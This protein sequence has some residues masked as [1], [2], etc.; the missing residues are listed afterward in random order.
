[1]GEREM[2]WGGIEMGVCWDWF[3][4]VCMVLLL[5]GFFVITARFFSVVV[6]VLAWVF[7]GVVDVV[8][9]G[10]D[11]RAGRVFKHGSIFL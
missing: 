5:G 2:I 3:V 4:C 11:L 7:F 8:S 1:M 6:N 10:V 9:G